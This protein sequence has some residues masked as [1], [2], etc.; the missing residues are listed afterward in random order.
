MK[1]WGWRIPFAIG[2]LAAVV[3]FF[4]RRSLA[5]TTTAAARQQKKAGTIKGVLRY[6]R[7]FAIVLGFTAGGTLFFYAFTTYMQKYLVN[8]A[9]MN[10][11]T[12]NTIITIV[13]F[14]FMLLQ[15]LFGAISDRIGRRN[16]MLCFGVLSML[17]AAPILAALS[18]VSSP[19]A[20]FG[21]VLLAL[22]I[23]SFYTAISGVV[24]AELFPMHVRAMGVGCRMRWLTR[25]SAEALSTWRCGSSPLGS[26][27]PSSGTSR[28]CAAS[29]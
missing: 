3:V 28:P 4:L 21:L 17:G 24:K 29:P 10:P 11:N 5:E 26:R 22:T 25:L 19:Y 13:L 27:R 7:S 15:P 9:G 16:S 8:T 18:T 12:S 6:G 23:A 20:A 14:C 1:A 2:A